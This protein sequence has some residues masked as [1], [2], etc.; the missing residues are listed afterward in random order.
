MLRP[1]LQLVRIPAVFSSLSNA[2]AGWWIGGAIAASVGA[3]H[4]SVGSLILGLIA[5]GL[6]LLAGMA[7]NDIADLEVDRRERPSRP[8]P[9]G[10][11]SLRQAWTLV[12][13][14]FAT[15]LLCQ[16]IANPVSAVA[17][18][19]LVAAIFLYNF[20]LKG[21][22]LG[23]LSM[24]LCRVLNLAGALALGFPSVKTFGALP[25][26]AYGAL[27]SLGF[28]VALVTY[29]ARDEVTGNS[30]GRVRLFFIG[31]AAWFS[32]W[33]A[34]AATNHSL[35]SLGVVAVLVLH[36]FL[37]KDALAGL[38]SLPGSPA[39]TGKTVGGMLGSMPVTDAL[40]MFAT[41]AAWPAALAGLLWMLP[42]KRLARRFYST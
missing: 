22:A 26:A 39:T 16:S 23:P 37:L 3:A 15:G 9:S 18:L 31:F 4:P 20:V 13:A 25:P 36:L 40:A 7:L 14:F 1:Y 21:T 34:F 10:A 8:L 33:A 17:G 35:A 19:F 41:G 24:G 28:Y 27:V 6:Y 42:G 5:A 11:L 38:R 12:V 2:W 30:A 32:G 29:L